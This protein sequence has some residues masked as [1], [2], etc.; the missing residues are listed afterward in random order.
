[1]MIPTEPA[2]SIARLAELLAAAAAGVPPPSHRD[3]P[4]RARRRA[5][6]LPK[7]RQ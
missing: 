1:M 2:G 7:G 6:Q 4:C 5:M 3:L